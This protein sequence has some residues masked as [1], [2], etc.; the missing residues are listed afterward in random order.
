MTELNASIRDIPLPARLARRPVSEKGFPVPWFVTLKTADG[1]WDFV[2]IDPR[3][4]A[5][6]VQRRVCWTCGEPLGRI[7]AFV[8]GPMCSVN[9]LSAEPPTCGECAEYA[10][11]A[12]PFLANPNMRRNLKAAHDPTGA[13]TPGL[14]L[15]HNPTATLIWLT[16]HWE[17]QRGTGL[18]RI[19]DPVAVAWYK[20]GR[21]ATRADIDAAFEIGLPK[22]R[23]AANAQGFPAIADLARKLA[24]ARTFLPR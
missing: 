23:E 22:L 15:Q 5:E 9:R 18:H 13:S 16:K 21:T 3:R 6:A 4:V 17:V 19:G 11:R 2:N 1:K 7:V 12:C 24:V 14:M 10:V 20:E 8:I